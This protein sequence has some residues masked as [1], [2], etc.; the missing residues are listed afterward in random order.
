MILPGAQQEKAMPH[1]IVKL[2]PGRSE[3]QKAQLAQAIVQNLMAIANSSEPSISVAIEEVAPQ[4]WPEAVY[5][6]DILGTRGKLYKQPGY[7]PFR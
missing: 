1:V 2:Y 5:R 7:D 6:P 3:E 4:D